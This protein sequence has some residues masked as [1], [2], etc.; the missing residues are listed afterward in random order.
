MDGWQSTYALRERTVAVLE[1]AAAGRASPDD[2]AQLLVDLRATWTRE[3]RW[4]NNEGPRRPVLHVAGPV[5]AC[6]EYRRSCPGFIVDRRQACSTCGQELVR[7]RWAMFFDEGADVAALGSVVFV[8]S[9]T[10]AET[11]A[12]DDIEESACA[13]SG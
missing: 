13:T 12:C 9:G 1:A 11:V 2:A 6:R 8:L 3:K 5:I 7:G 4:R 10:T